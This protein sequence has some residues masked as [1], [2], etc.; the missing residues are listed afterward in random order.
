LRSLNG[1]QNCIINADGANAFN[2]DAGESNDAV[3]R[4]FSIINAGYGIMCEGASPTIEY[5]IIRDG[6]S[7]ICTSINWSNGVGS[8]PIIR[9]N[10]I[11]NNS[12]EG[13]Q[14]FELGNPQIINNTIVG[15]LTYGILTG[16]VDAIVVNNIIV[17]S[18]TGI[19]KAAENDGSVISRYNC[20]WK[21]TNNYQGF[22][23]GTGDISSDPLFVGAGDYNLQ[24]N[25]PCI[26]AG[27]PQSL[28]DPDGTIA[29]IGAL[30]LHHEP[31][32]LTAEF[33]ADVTSGEAPLLVNLTDKSSGSPTYWQWEFGDGARAAIQNPQHK[34][35][36]PGAYDVMLITGNATETDTIRKTGYIEV[37]EKTV[38][39]PQLDGFV[40]LN[41]GPGVDPTHYYDGAFISAN[42]AYIVSSHNKLYK[43]TDGGQTWVDVS[44]EPAQNFDGLGVTPRVSFINEDIGCV[45]FSLDDGSNNYNYDV[46]FGYVWCTRDGGQTWS[47]RFD[48]NDDQIKHLQ[49]I[50]ENLVYVSGTARLG[51]TST[52][53]FKKITWDPQNEAYTVQSIAPLPTSRP[54]VNA[55]DWLN[56]N[57]GVALG[58]LNVPPWTNEPFITRDG[59]ATWSSIKG[60]LPSLDNAYPGVSDNSIHILNEITFLFMYYKMVDSQYVTSI[61]KT[62]DGGVSWTPAAFD[63]PA[64]WL[65]SFYIDRDS[66]LGIAVGGDSAHAC[67]IT[68]DAGYTWQLQSLPGTSAQYYPY[69]VGIA[70][71]GTSWIIGTNRSIWKTVQAPLADF[72]ADI[73]RGVVPL[74]VQFTDNSRS[75]DVLITSWQWDFGDGS[76]SAVQNPLYTYE[77]Y[78]LYTVTLIVSNGIVSDTL[79]LA[80]FID[81]LA[82]G[83]AFIT[84]VT[85]VPEDQG[86]WVTVTFQKSFYDTATPLG[87]TTSASGDTVEMYTVEINDG[88]GWI[89]ANSMVAYGADSYE[90]LAHTPIDSSDISD[91]KLLFRIIA[92]MTEGIFISSEVA[93]YSVDNLK[94]HV[95]TG[96][97]SQ[98][99][100]DGSVQLDWDEPIDEDFQYFM[101]YRSMVADF[102]PVGMEPYAKLTG[103]YFVDAE[104]M[105]AGV[106]YYRIVSVDFHGNKSDYSAVI[107]ATISAIDELTGIPM[108]F[109]LKANYP[110]PFNPMTHIPYELPRASKVS[111]RIYD[112]RG[113]LVRIL[114]NE[115]KNPGYHL[116]I[117]D[118][119]DE[120]GQAVASG[121]YLLHF[122]T[123]GYSARSKLLL[124]R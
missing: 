73:R 87:K 34:Y 25:S 21:N 19:V 61:W 117:W 99:A 103:N 3:I 90:L 6:T 89:A 7:G 100:G 51:V 35:E 42:I 109:A 63:V 72:T 33:T 11:L 112:A 22:V 86:G 80:N 94:P 101:V 13:I 111:I 54:H 69:S 124:I 64:A 45:S 12:W 32:A 55:A 49:Q 78:G 118:A 59:G 88:S 95:P 41:N 30:Y 106:Y 29:D 9:F 68:R 84:G 91:G 122:Q 57:V 104:T 77:N 71:D 120:S 39:Q 28:P 56:Q 50:T 110:N 85:D 17:G 43:T 15:N 105:P 44:P 107:S 2:F 114:I 83:Q 74:T 67:Y 36:T 66:N 82:L 75:E 37:L 53:W 121:V 1:A 16:F 48:V 113:G 18:E 116:A 58:Q 92:G 102:D 62:V 123:A 14:V 60:N 20:V 10:Q 97:L 23:A 40:K 79:V 108:E 93:G 52:R 98:V 26:D 5:C 8:S 27:D 119:R 81:A 24:S 4:G 65:F 96:L 46:V 47:Q 76:T 38:Q 115:N 31:I 70:G